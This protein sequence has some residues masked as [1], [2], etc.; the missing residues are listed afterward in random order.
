MSDPNESYNQG[1]W[2]MGPGPNVN[3][4]QYQIGKSIRDAN[5]A[6]NAPSTPFPQLGGDSFTPFSPPA[7][8]GYTGGYSG[9]VEL[10]RPIAF[11]F[12]LPVFIVLLPFWACLYPVGATITTLAVLA[13]AGAI[14]AAAPALAAGQFLI[15]LCAAAATS[16]WL[17]TR[18]EQWLGR[19]VAYRYARYALRFVAFTITALRVLLPGPVFAAIVSRPE[20]LPL[21]LQAPGSLLIAFGFAGFMHLLS[22]RGAADWWHGLL[23]K[24]YLRPS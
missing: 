13:L 24:L 5:A 11:I 17:C 7:N 23:G 16:I 8:Y 15:V 2:G 12:A 21:L 1:L 19:F 6:A 9:P 18:A 22:Q 20:R 14:H 10:P 3:W 4:D